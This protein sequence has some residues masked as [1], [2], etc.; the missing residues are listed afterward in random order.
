MRGRQL[1]THM[2]RKQLAKVLSIAWKGAPLVPHDKSRLSKLLSLVRYACNAQCITL[3]LY[4]R[5]NDCDPK[6]SLGKC[7]QSMRRTAL[8]QDIGLEPRKTAHCVERLASYKSGVEQEQRRF[9]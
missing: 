2:C 8:D 4:S 5:W 3:S 9:R 7:K 6:P 1:F